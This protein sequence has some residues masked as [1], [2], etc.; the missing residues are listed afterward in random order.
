MNTKNDSQDLPPVTDVLMSLTMPGTIL[1]YPE[2]PL[3]FKE[4][5]QQAVK[6]LEV[7]VS[8]TESKDQSILHKLHTKMR[9]M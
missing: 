7:T 2:K 4:S 5:T 1:T 9:D 8:S 6:T 3:T